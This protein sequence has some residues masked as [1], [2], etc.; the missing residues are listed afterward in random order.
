MSQERRSARGRPLAA[1]PAPAGDTAPQ[2]GNIVLTPEQ[3]ERLLNL[4]QTANNQTTAA[5][6]NQPIAQAP[7]EPAPFALSPALVNMSTPIDFTTLEGNK[8]NNA[9]IAALSYKL[10]VES[11]SI[12]TFN[13][14]LMDRCIPQDGINHQRMS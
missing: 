10:D 2:G 11:Q 3:F 14:I 5:I 7:I 4:A 8:L 13:E 6:G 9:S 12:N 1:N